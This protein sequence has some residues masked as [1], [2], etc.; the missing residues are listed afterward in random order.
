MSELYYSNQRYK[1]RT[2]VSRCR[3]LRQQNVL[4]AKY[5]EQSKYPR[6]HFSHFSHLLPHAV[7]TNELLMGSQI[8]SKFPSILLVDHVD[9]K[10]IILSEAYK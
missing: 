4:P 2:C 3:R 1:W 9:E 5:G 10:N 6:V 8:V 7:S